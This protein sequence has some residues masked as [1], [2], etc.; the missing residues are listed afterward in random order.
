MIRAGR[1]VEGRVDGSR[2]AVIRLWLARAVLLSGTILYVR[3]GLRFLLDPVPT[4][5]RF[6]I[7]LDQPLAVTTVRAIVGALFFGLGT[8]ALT[9]LIFRSQT[10]NC[11]R[12]IVSFIF[13]VLVGRVV[14]L[15]MDGTDPITVSELRNESIAFAV[16]AVA[17]ALVPRQTVPGP[18]DGSTPGEASS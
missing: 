1:R 3:I 15:Q 8:T 14:G 16:Y 5:A 18:I 7:T 9:G 2:V 4:I 13:F 10:A 12:V 17:L 6:G 11:L